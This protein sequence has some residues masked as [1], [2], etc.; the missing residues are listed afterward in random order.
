MQITYNET[1]AP[2]EAATKNPISEHY[3]DE[4]AA[5]AMKQSVQKAVLETSNHR[6]LCYHAT[7]LMSLI[8]GICVMLCDHREMHKECQGMKWAI[9]VEEFSVLY[10]TLRH[11]LYCYFGDSTD[12]EGWY[13]K[14]RCSNIGA[15]DSY[16]KDS[17]MLGAD[18]K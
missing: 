8:Q 5:A 6:T 7:V 2:K 3:S 11:W 13:V 9:F 17:W 14:R 16:P 1:G 4:A 10:I 15:L 12:A 18:T